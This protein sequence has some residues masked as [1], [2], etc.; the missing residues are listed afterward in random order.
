ME[1]MHGRYLNVG[2]FGFALKMEVSNKEKVKRVDNDKHFQ[3]LPNFN[4]TTILT[5]SF[6]RIVV[7][8]VT[9][10][11]VFNVCRVLSHAKRGYHFENLMT[12]HQNAHKHQ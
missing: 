7:S 2:T 9:Y 1:N 10:Y 11:I 8:A 3:R 12:S 5:T 4:R 6:F